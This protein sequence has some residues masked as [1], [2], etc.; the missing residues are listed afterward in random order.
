ME[1]YRSGQIITW[2]SIGEIFVPQSGVWS[3]PARDLPPGTHYR[4]QG[5]I[6]VYPRDIQ[7]SGGLALVVSKEKVLQPWMR[8]SSSIYRPGR[9][10]HSLSQPRQTRVEMRFD[11]A[12]SV[13]RILVPY[14]GS[15]I[16]VWTLAGGEITPASAAIVNVYLRNGQNKREKVVNRL[17]LLNQ[18]PSAEI[19][20]SLLRSFGSF[21][22]A[23]TNTKLLNQ[24]GV[25]VT[26]I[27]EGAIRPLEGNRSI[28]EFIHRKTFIFRKSEEASEAS[29]WLRA[30]HLIEECRPDAAK[31]CLL[32]VDSNLNQLDLYNRR[33]LPLAH[34]EFLPDGWMLMY[35]SS[36]AGTRES[37]PNM[38]IAGS[39]RA[40]NQAFR[41]I[42]K[43]GLPVDWPID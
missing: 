14:D 23:D 33:E 15:P 30:I 34:G 42:K 28:L 19:H 17:T 20:T 38:M 7:P 40:S 25:C 29:G 43:Q 27:C 24:S 31:P 6:H 4:R 2:K 37:L 22:S 35:A 39:D 26:S 32:V 41:E 3:P 18:L 16:R 9:S 11:H 13:D 5:W 21:F 36:N 12:I 8:H 1:W 10:G